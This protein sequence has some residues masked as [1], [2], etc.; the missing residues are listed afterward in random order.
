MYSRNDSIK[1]CLCVESKGT[2][3]ILGQSNLPI[4]KSMTPPP[5]GANYRETYHHHPGYRDSQDY[6][7]RADSAHS[8]GFWFQVC[9]SNG[10]T[11]T[12][13]ETARPRV[14][15]LGLIDRR[16]SRFAYLEQGVRMPRGNA[17]PGCCVCYAG[18][19]LRLST[20]FRGQL[21]FGLLE[22]E[23]GA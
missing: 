9:C 13:A 17:E 19:C 7:S 8:S 15:A 22:V 3:S 18:H 12:C 10:L 1:T 11:P 23:C 14:M 4:Y 5:E 21:E 6:P 20:R 16:L 2:P